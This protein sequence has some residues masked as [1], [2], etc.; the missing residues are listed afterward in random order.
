[1][2]LNDLQKQLIAKYKSGTFNHSGATSEE[3][4]AFMEIINAAEALLESWMKS[5]GLWRQPF[6][7][8]NFGLKL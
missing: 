6:S 4:A 2:E 5:E 7:C 3:Q 1:M 8:P